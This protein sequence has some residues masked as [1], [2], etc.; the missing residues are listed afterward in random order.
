VVDKAASVEQ[1][2][3]AEH[4]K[5]AEARVQTDTT[6]VAARHL[7]VAVEVEPEVSAEL[8]EAV[9]AAAAVEFYGL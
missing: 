5:H 3:A 9:G 7:A 4:N 1:V 2:A 6:A 8:L